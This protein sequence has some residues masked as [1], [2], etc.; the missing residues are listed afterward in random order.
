VFRRH[1]IHQAEEE[2]GEPLGRAQGPKS[3]NFATWHPRV[4]FC[5]AAANA[6]LREGVREPAPRKL[7]H[8]GPRRGSLFRDP[9]KQVALQRGRAA[10]LRTPPRDPAG[11][12]CFGLGP[13]TLGGFVF[14]RRLIHQAEEEEGEPLGRASGLKS[15]NFATW[16]PGVHFCRAAAD[17]RQGRQ[18]SP[19]PRGPFGHLR[20]Q[21]P[22]STPA[23]GLPRST[24]EQAVEKRSASSPR[25]SCR[26]FCRTLRRE[27]H[28]C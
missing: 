3:L 19:W 21:P 16:H 10:M 13:L 17:K 2:E 18:K 15:L 25:L 7:A 4:H 6:L 20:Q 1:L 22:G 28:V 23:A 24:G 11:G 5:R 12:R 27:T 9:I 8:T 14:R 26:G